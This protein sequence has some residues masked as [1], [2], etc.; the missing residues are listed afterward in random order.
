MKNYVLTLILI[1]SLMILL[2][3][4]TIYATNT[5]IGTVSQ[6][7][8]VSEADT[9]KDIMDEETLIGIMAK[10]IPNTNELEALKADAVAIRTYMARRILGL[11]SKGAIV[12][13][14]RDEMIE[15]W[16]K[17]NFYD[18][19]AL[20]KEAVDETKCEIMMYNN[21]PIE[22]VF[23]KASSGKTRSAK[24]AYNEDIPYLQS[25]DSVKDTITN[26]KEISYKDA[27]ALIKNKY[28]DYKGETVQN[29]IQVIS[30][31]DAGYV[32]SVQVGNITL[33]GDEVRS[34][35]GL[36]SAAFKIYFKDNSLLFDIKGEGSGIGL[37]LNGAN[38]LAKAGMGYE[39]ILK[40]YFT[41][42]D[43]EEYELQ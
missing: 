31:D 11:Q 3:V 10:E 35:F 39:D 2:P 17:D 30:K 27:T 42:V 22:A 37:S 19:Y 16:G 1:G 6:T 5:P 34:L 13:Y 40:L 36:Q 24:D 7:P 12:G 29:Q 15:L 9:K 43:L 38:E 23:H 20:Y 32:N 14:T 41:G 26:Q 25:V 8:T 21:V 28:P 18:T 33:T 4:L